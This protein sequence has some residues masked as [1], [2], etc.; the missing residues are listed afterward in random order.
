MTVGLII[1]IVY[2]TAFSYL[3]AGLSTTDIVR[4][5]AGQKRSVLT[6]DCYCENCGC[7]IPLSNQLPIISHLM[8]RGHCRNCD[9]KIPIL[10]F[11]LECA[12]FAGMLLIGILFR[13]KSTAFL[14]SILY[15]ELFKI[16]VLLY[17][18]VRRERFMKQLTLS[19]LINLVM[20][21]CG[22]LLFLMMELLIP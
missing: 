18:S 20:F 2:F 16:G 1:R 10:Q 8:N 6:H 15:Y 19:L 13:F 3:V 12:L 5:T 17:K 4:L 14:L 21:S 9:A 7:M 11:I 22:F